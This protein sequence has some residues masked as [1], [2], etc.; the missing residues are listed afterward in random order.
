MTTTAIVILVL[1]FFVTSV[2][3]VVTG[4]NSLIAVP[5][6][7]QV[8]IDARTA[9]ATN[10][11]ALVFMAIGGA[12]PFARS[13]HIERGSIIPLAIV[14]MIASATGAILASVSG[15]LGIRVVVSTAMIVVALFSIF[16]NPK[17]SEDSKPRQS[18][19]VVL[20]IAA[21]ILGI[22]GGYF[23][24]GYVTLLTAAF[25][26]FGGMGYHTAVGT[27]KV[28]NI[29]SSLAA[30]IVFAIYGL[31]DYRLGVILGV[32]MF[33]GAYVG[34]HLATRMDE[35]MIKKIFIGS[36]FL[37]AAKSIYDIIGAFI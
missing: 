27:T 22:Y 12:I 21:G 20:L 1:I 9:V 7:F 17:R 2:I 18:S 34:G 14:T 29:F 37:L 26:G 4:S 16:Y 23:S 6:M 32:T 15:D 13:G 33:V 24:G 31:I 3:G 5:A 36:V 19:L 25:V 28:V 11:F 10:M 35:S 30:T 8:G